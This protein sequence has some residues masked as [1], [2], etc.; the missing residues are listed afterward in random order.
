MA[1]LEHALLIA[2]LAHA[3]QKDKGGQPY[4]LHPLRMM[5]KL[6]TEQERMVALLHDVLEDTEVTL[7]ELQEAGFDEQVLQA[8]QDLTRM[9]GEDRMQAAR[10]AAANPLALQVKLVDNADNLSPGR[11]AEPDAE[12]EARF[13]EYRRIRRYLLQEARKLREQKEAS[14]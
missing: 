4:V 3:G 2:A 9:P 5:L 11:I 14:L 6:E 1:S 13:K 10:R 12:D 8:V 7:E